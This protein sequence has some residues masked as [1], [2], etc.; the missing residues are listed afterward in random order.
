[1]AYYAIFIIRIVLSWIRIYP[2]NRFLGEAMR[3]IYDMTEPFLAFC[4]RL[5][6]PRPGLPFDFSPIVGF[7]ILSLID[8]IITRIFA[9]IVY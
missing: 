2:K 9:A 1:M 4:R 3:F 7:L 8:A 6:P 5:L